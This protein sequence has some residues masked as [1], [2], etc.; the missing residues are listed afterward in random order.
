MNPTSNIFFCWFGLMK[1]KALKD[2][3]ID[4]NGLVKRETS[5][6]LPLLAQ[7]AL[8][9]KIVSIPRVLKYYRVH[10]ESVY[11]KQNKSSTKIEKF[12]NEIIV[13]SILMHITYTSNLR[14]SEK[15]ILYLT[16]FLTGFKLFKILLKQA[17]INGNL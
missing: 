11:M 1:T 6:E 15:I 7:L 14:Y 16:T 5:S 4:Y 17:K 10:D 2:I 9:G 3:S 12:K 8:I 13:S